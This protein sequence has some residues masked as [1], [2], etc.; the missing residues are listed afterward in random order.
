MYIFDK[1]LNIPR[2]IK[3]FFYIAI[4]KLKF[5]LCGVKLGLNSQIYTQV[6]LQNRGNISIGNNFIFTSGE[7]F[8]PLCR[9]IRGGIC[10]RKNAN[11]IIGNNV[12]ISSACI[13]AIDRIEIGNNVLIGGDSLIVDSDFHS[14]NYLDRRNEELDVQNRVSKSVVIEDDVLIG[15]RVVILK[16]VHIGARSIIAAGSIVTKDIPSDCVAGGNPCIP[17]RKL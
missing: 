17:I 6:Y 5:R 7:M 11:I 9:N 12:G 1:I 3:R 8:N 13:W 2:A 10:A 4:N 15:T 16:G 14:L